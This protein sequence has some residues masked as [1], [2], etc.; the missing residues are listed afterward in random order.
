[1][2]LAAKC[3]DKAGE[4][5]RRD[6]ALAYLSFTEIDQE[7]RTK[8]RGKQGVEFR[9]KLYA[10]TEQLLEANDVSFLDK[11]ALCLLH[12]GEQE[13]YTAEL[14]ELYARLRYTQRINDDADG[15][16]TLPLAPSAHEKKYF[17]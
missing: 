6:Y 8:L 10:I 3:F 16:L 1:M 14:F 7:D 4:P 5:K 12:T 17:G 13:E 9:S 2:R 15:D 11:A